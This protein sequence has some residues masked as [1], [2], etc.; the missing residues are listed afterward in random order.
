MKLPFS[1]IKKERKNSFC[2]LDI[3]TCPDG[4][5]LMGAIFN[6]EKINYF[7]D[8]KNF[9]KILRKNQDDKRYRLIIAHYGGG[10]DY[11]H[12]IEWIL[13]HDYKIKI[14]LS[15][16]KI[17]IFTLYLDDIEITF[18][19]SS[20]V[21]QSG[22]KDLCQK[23]KVETQ[24]K[25][26]DIKNIKSIFEK[27]KKEGM[28]YLRND[29][30][31]LYEIC[32]KF[33]I[34]LNLK[35]F[36]VTI[37]SLAMYIF[38]KNFLQKSYHRETR[39]K[40]IDF[41]EKSYSGGRVECFRVGQHK[42]VYVYDVNSLYPF[43][44]RNFPVP[45]GCC[46]K[47]LSYQKGDTGFYHIKFN[48]KNKTIPP[49]LWIKSKNGLEFVYEG[50]GVF[51]SGEIEKAVEI[52]IKF[53]LIEGWEFIKKEFLFT[54]FVEHF[55]KLRFE[56]KDMPL[57]LCCKII[58]NSLYGKFSEKEESE[59]LERLSKDELDLIY[60]QNKILKE[61]GKK[62]IKITPYKLEFDLY[63][64]ADER[65]VNHR[66]PYISSAITSHARVHLYNLLV[67]YP[68]NIIYCDTDSIHL[69]CEINDNE[70]IS[71]EIGKLKLEKSGEGIYIGRKQYYI[72]GVMKMKGIPLKSK[73]EKDD[74]TKDDFIDILNGKSKKFNYSQ[75]PKLKSNLIRGQKAS[76]TVKTH[77]EIKK[78]DY[79]S[80]F[81]GG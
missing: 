38:R 64:V 33:M 5:L 62:E 29:V 57:D 11:I 73:L 56:N 8:W 34:E 51:Y 1:P 46:I 45:I 13:R 61:D 15:G 20:N 47:T 42:S 10:F 80:N 22:L 43:I 60:E 71:N 6:G 76:K 24:K 14:I 53:E 26:I 70:L 75:F 58:L 78:G 66:Q 67:Q 2:T 12:F 65:E 52:G 23:M 74:L 49:L 27:N 59:Q 18:S 30:V 17:I 25:E 55:Y 36:P 19:D 68:K 69:D 7:S 50:E 9:I 77:R 44:M 63:S 48:Q 31:S 16:S 21:M 40:I 54:D 39:P 3:E 32:Q 79:L 35:Y 72:D 41:I 37:S 4:N 28:E 81:K